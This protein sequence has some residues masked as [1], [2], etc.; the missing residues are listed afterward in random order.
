MMVVCDN[1]DCLSENH[2]IIEKKVFNHRNNKQKIKELFLY[3]VTSS[4]FEGNKNELSAYTYNR[5]KKRVKNK[6]LLVY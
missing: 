5:D 4:Y 6:L 1:L 2:A 3:D